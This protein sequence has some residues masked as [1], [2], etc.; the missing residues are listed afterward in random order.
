MKPAPDISLPH[1]DGSPPKKT[2]APLELE[3]M[4]KLQALQYHGF[5]VAPHGINPKMGMEVRQ[6]TED[7][8]RV[9]AT[10]TVSPC[11]KEGIL[12][13]CIPID[14]AQWKQHET[15]LK[16]SLMRPELVKDPSTVFELGQTT[17]NGTTMIFQY[18]LGQTQPIAQPAGSGSAGSAGS[19][20]AAKK[21][22]V[23]KT[24]A[25]AGSGSAG[26][27]SAGSAGSG[28]AAEADFGPGHFAWTHAYTL[29]WND[30]Q[31]QIRVVA[32]YKDD[33]LL[34]KEAMAKEVPRADLENVAK[35]F[36]DV[37][38]QAW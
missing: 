6:K 8:P 14:L 24:P 21:P 38:T 20:S 35:A 18:Q 4:Q 10:I 29:Y 11:T 5:Q 28:S 34:N 30:G 9:W 37:Y 2:T 17:L 3:T 32:E 15:E 25:K 23:P 13:D 27:G 26:S 12:K 1:G 19:G 7:H 31:N 16:A 33:P 22:P 36:M